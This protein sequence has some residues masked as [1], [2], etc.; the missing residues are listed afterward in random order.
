MAGLN[1][2]R[3]VF[4]DSSGSRVYLSNT[5]ANS[6]VVYDTNLNMVTSYPATGTISVKMLDSKLFSLDDTNDR[7]WMMNPADGSVISTFRKFGDVAFT[8]PL[9]LYLVKSTNYYLYVLEDANV[10]RFDFGTSLW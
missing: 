7:V 4:Y 1:S 5:G 3:D 9:A 2:P 8:T 6:V 10:Q